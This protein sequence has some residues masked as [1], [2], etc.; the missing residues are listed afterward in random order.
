VQKLREGLVRNM[1]VLAQTMEEAKA[2]ERQAV[3]GAGGNVWDQWS[4]TILGEAEEE[5]RIV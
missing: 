2:A 1:P 5:K 3:E 4:K